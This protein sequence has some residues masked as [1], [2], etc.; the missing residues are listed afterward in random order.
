MRCAFGGAFLCVCSALTRLNA[1]VGFLSEKKRRQFFT[2]SGPAP[3]LYIFYGGIVLFTGAQSAQ[4]QTASGNP[5]SARCTVYLYHLQQVCYNL[6]NIL[7]VLK[8]NKL[9][10]LQGIH[11]KWKLFN[12]TTYK[13]PANIFIATF[14]KYYIKNFKNHIFKSI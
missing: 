4:T 1:S 10:Q 8:A 5:D 9:V 2:A 3:P 11:R 13:S 14:Q 6:R 7:T 12:N